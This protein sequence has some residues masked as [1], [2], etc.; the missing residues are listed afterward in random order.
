MTE[1]HGSLSIRIRALSSAGLWVTAVL[2]SGAAVLA[3][4][5]AAIV[6][7]HGAGLW[8][9][10]HPV[11]LAIGVVL[12]VPVIGL[13]PMLGAERSEPIKTAQAAQM[14]MAVRLG[15]AGA[16]TLAVLLLLA[17]QQARLTFGIWV[18][19][20]YLV[21]LAAEMSILAIWL[22]GKPETT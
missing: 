1:G 20:L 18:V 3:V 9:G 5:G 19:G 7:L 11:F 17:G 6:V 22:K 10:W 4:S 15:T 21:S 2:V 16:A 12:A 13:L 8:A 14:A